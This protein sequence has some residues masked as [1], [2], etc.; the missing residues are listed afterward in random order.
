MGRVV[1]SRLSL[2]EVANREEGGA[3]FRPLSRRALMHI[4]FAIRRA[5]AFLAEA[6]PGGP[7]I[8]SSRRAHTRHYRR[9]LAVRTVKLGGHLTRA[10]TEATIINVSKNLSSALTLLMATHTFSVLKESGGSVVT[11]AVPYFNAASEACRGTYRVSGGIKTA[12]V[13]IPVTSTIGIRFH[14]VKRSPRSRD[15]ACRGYRTERHARILVS[16]TGG[17]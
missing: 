4:P 14:S 13:R 12:L 8:P 1:C 16:V 3:A 10:G 2:R 17:A 11:I 7:F 6:F 15:M 5:G 9:V